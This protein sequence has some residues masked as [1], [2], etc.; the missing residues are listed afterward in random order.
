[1]TIDLPLARPAFVTRLDVIALSIVLASVG[2][3][4]LLSLLTAP[5]PQVP[6]VAYIYPALGGVQNVWFA[7]LDDPAS[8]MQMTTTEYGIYDFAVSADGRYLA[9]AERIEP[10]GLHEIML[11]NL[12]TRQVT[13]VTNC[14]ADDAD[15]RG[16]AFRPTG[17]AIAYERVSVNT[18]IGSGIGTIR[19]WLADISAPPY[20]NQPLS[21]D[22]QFIGYSPVWSGD[23]NALAFYS[24]D[25]TSP[26]ILIY[27]F[28]PSEGEQTLKLV[29][30]QYG[31]V[32]GLAPNGEQLAFPDASRRSDGSVY[33]FLR[34]ADLAKLEFV[35]LTSP[36]DNVD[37]I[38]AVWHND[39]SKV[40]ILRRYTDE[41][42]T[43]GHQLYDLDM[44]TR[45]VTPLIVDENY[46]HGFFTF[47]S[48][49]TMIVMQRF[50]FN[51]DSAMASQPQ[52]WVYAMSDGTLTRITDN[53]YHP[54]WVYGATS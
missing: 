13:Q 1:M 52:V 33:S 24:A 39:G 48:S 46:S 14:V 36:E 42:Y 49:G 20:S 53:A 47:D 25:V 15:C 29:P 4:A 31:T 30:S 54:R 40:A 35:D 43:R 26:G 41:R 34:L 3:I 9:Y 2:V 16:A 21:Q 38:D 6:T 12:Q 37:D 32:G 22:S 17:N 10:A 50:P 51:T 45:E 18:G 7:P 8:A 19:I 28:N 44:T 27:N 5:S 11:L 23:G